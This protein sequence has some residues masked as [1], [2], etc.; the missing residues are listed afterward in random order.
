MSCLLHTFHFDVETFCRNL[1][2]S[3]NT[4]V[5]RGWCLWMV[6]VS[7]EMM[8]LAIC[9][10]I[11]LYYQFYELLTSYFSFSFSPISQNIFL[12]IQY[13]RDVL[14]CLCM[15]LHPYLKK[16]VCICAFSPWK[17]FADTGFICIAVCF[18]QLHSLIQCQINFST[19]IVDFELAHIFVCVCLCVTKS[20]CVYVVLI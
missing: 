11:F 9:T 20:K 16:R 13:S 18:N 12:F 5:T 7:S 4:V 2:Y 8:F 3:Y 17:R 19:S 10:L 14:C 1:F 15:L 6:S